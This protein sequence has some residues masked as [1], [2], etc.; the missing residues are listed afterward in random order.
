MSKS[1]LKSFLIAAIK[2]FYGCHPRIVKMSEYTM[3]S[4]YVWWGQAFEMP[5]E[6]GK[7]EINL[8]KDKGIN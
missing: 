3:G 2:Q 4:C 5:F 6:K 7:L 8:N 1:C